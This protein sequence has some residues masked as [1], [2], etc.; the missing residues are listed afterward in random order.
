MDENLTNQ[1][2]DETVNTSSI[3]KETINALPLAGYDGPIHLIATQEEARDAVSKLLTERILGFD[4]ETRPSFRPGE[5]Y[6]AALLQLAGA[7]GVYLF[8]LLQIP[9]LTEV[10]N[11]LQ[12]PSIVKAGVAIRD[13]IRK[14]QERI[15]FVPQGF[16]ELSD[17]TQKVGILNT[18][19]RSLAA[20]YLGVRVSKGSQVSNWSKRVLTPAQLKYAAIDAWISRSLY[21]KLADLGLTQ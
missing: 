21:V 11:L 3:S 13:D 19:L 10:Y 20:I 8:Q 5:S 9:D 12:D 7:D 4:T 2:A 17:I 16:I 14:L 1:A 18:G 6:P 15:P